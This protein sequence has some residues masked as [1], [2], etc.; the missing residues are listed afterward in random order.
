M[1]Y[2]LETLKHAI[3]HQFGGAEALANSVGM[4]EGGSREA[5]HLAAIQF[6]QLALDL[7]ADVLFNRAVARREI[8]RHQAAL[9]RLNCL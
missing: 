9:A 7:P 3:Q 1:S 5:L 4:A 6:W 2:D 8:D